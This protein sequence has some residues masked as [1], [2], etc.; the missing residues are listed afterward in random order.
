MW[1]VH[2]GAGRMIEQ[3]KRRWALMGDVADSLRMIGASFEPSEYA[4]P[5][6]HCEDGCAIQRQ[7]HTAILVEL[8]ADGIAGWVQ[9]PTCQY[10]SGTWGSF[11]PPQRCTWG[12][13][14]TDDRERI[15][16]TRC[17]NLASQTVLVTDD[18]RAVVRT[19]LRLCEGHVTWAGQHLQ[20]HPVDPAT[21]N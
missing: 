15:A 9:C 19:T 1:A 21:M 5:C 12:W 3:T 10:C 16:N 20:L 13:N 17:V 14:M 18:E 11:M 4:G 2:E 7:D 6:P 8:N